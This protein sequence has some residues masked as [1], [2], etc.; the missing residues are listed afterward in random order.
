MLPFQFFIHPD[1]Y[2]RLLWMAYN[3]YD[4]SY[5]SSNTQHGIAIHVMPTPPSHSSKLPTHLCLTPFGLLPL[6]VLKGEIQIIIVLLG[7][8]NYLK[9]PNNSLRFNGAKLF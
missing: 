9:C 6:L 3:G 4:A 8:G 5:N 7:Y 1:I 2:V